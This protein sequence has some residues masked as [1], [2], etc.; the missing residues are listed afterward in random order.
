MHIS[1]KSGALITA[2]VM[3]PNLMWVL[4]PHTNPGENSPVPAALNFAE[5]VGRI[6]ILVIPFFYSITLGKR[7]S[8]P[9]LFIAGLALALY[10]GAWIRYFAGGRTAALMGIPMLGIPLPLAITPAVFL[11]FSAYILGSWPML[12]ASVWFGVTHIWVSALT[13]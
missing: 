2:L 8:T 1:I 4:L 3:L 6:G 7:F 9:V 12:A 11:I 13:L 10:Y 5:N